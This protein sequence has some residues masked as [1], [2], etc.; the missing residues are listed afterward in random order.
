MSNTDTR[1]NDLRKVILQL[2]E[3]MGQNPKIDTMDQLAIENSIQML[4][5]V[6][7]SWKNRIGACQPGGECEDH[8]STRPPAIG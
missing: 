4:Q 6:Y 3:W 8:G 5:M 7:L 1:V 2:S